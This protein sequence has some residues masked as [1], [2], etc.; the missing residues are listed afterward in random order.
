MMQRF[1]ML[2]SLRSLRPLAEDEF[3]GETGAPLQLML[4]EMIGLKS[5]YQAAAKKQNFQSFSPPGR[6]K[7]PVADGKSKQ[8]SGKKR[9]GQMT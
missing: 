4:V 1:Q 8:N 2:G 7:A 3:T 9:A 5:G 6:R